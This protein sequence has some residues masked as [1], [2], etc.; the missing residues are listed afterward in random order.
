MAAAQQNGCHVFAQTAIFLTLCQYM[1]HTMFLTLCQH[2]NKTENLLPRFSVLQYYARFIY[3]VLFGAPVLPQ[4]TTRK[5][6]QFLSAHIFQLQTYGVQSFSFLPFCPVLRLV[7][8]PALYLCKDSHLISSITLHMIAILSLLSLKNLT[9]VSGKSLKSSPFW[10][11]I[12]I[13]HTAIKA[14]ALMLS[15]F[16]KKIIIHQTEPTQPP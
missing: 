14:C 8:C 6:Q 12:D 4:G 7:L 1:Y 2:K 15:T 5:F 16:C 11:Q 10:E 3:F 9:Q 13:H